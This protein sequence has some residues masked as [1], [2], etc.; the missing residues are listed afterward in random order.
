MIHIGFK[1]ICFVLL[2]C[3][4]THVSAQE[5]EGTPS[6]WIGHASYGM[7]LP[8]GDLADRFGRNF[9]TSI[10]VERLTGSNIIIGA[11]LKYLFGN[12][13][14]EDPLSTLR[15]LNVEI[16]G[17]NNF[18]ATVF[19]R[20]RGGYAGVTVGKLF[21]ISDKSRS[22]I[23]ATIGAGLFYHYIRLQDDSQAVP[24]IAGD[25][26][27][28]YDRLSRGPAFKQQIYWQ[29]LSNDKRLNYYIGL[30][31]MQG[32]TKNVRP[33]NY[34]TQQSVTDARF[35]MTIGV[36]VGWILPFYSQNFEDEEIYY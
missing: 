30:E 12:N 24:Q 6:A 34:D 22:G 15:N 35:D 11:D 36:R 25:Y 17:V 32:F 27:K 31:L 33:I 8:L 21:P 16:L 2:L 20:Q 4:F 23:R 13:V 9:Q 14:N 7:D 18:P 5:I 29:N 28:G 10:G 3:G 26:A 19:L 1:S